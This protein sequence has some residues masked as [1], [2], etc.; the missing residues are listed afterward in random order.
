MDDE[1]DNGEGASLNV[2]IDCISDALMVQQKMK[3]VCELN[4]ILTESDNILSQ[5]SP[6]YSLSY[7]AITIR[8]AKT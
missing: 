1:G 2:T 8:R 3:N 7:I 6:W 4:A 5:A